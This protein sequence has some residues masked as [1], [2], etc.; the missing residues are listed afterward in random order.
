MKINFFLLF[1]LFT[2]VLSV[3]TSCEEN[4]IPKEEL[5][6][7]LEI[8]PFSFHNEKG[9]GPY[10]FQMPDD[11]TLIPVRAF[12]GDFCQEKIDLATHLYKYPGESEMQGIIDL[13][14]NRVPNK[15][16]IEDLIFDS[17]SLV[18]G[19]QKHFGDPGSREYLEI[20][21]K[22]RNIYG[23][24]IECEGNGVASPIHFYL[25]DNVSNYI[26]GKLIIKYD[27]Y[28]KAKQSIKHIKT[29]ILEM[30]NSFEWLK[31]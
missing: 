11:W 21:D 9:S 1:T 23:Q 16:Y 5:V 31:D 28:K 6:L 26:H 10:S 8:E 14:Y 24:I 2:S 12:D 4:E 30:I 15:K 7:A 3:L 17:F 25:T 18:D 27:D 13:R 22:I 29:G 19:E 20:S